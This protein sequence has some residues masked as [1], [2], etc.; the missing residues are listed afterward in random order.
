M[1]QIVEDRLDQSTGYGVWATFSWLGR[2]H[3][4]EGQGDSLF[5]TLEKE[6]GVLVVCTGWM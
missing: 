4:Q 5:Q 2:R 6:M 3:G 1:A